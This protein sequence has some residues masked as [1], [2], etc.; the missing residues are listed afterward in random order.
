MLTKPLQGLPVAPV[1]PTSP[2]GGKDREAFE[3]EYRLGPLLGKGGFGT[4]FAGHRVT[5]R[6][7]VAIKVI[8]RNRVLGWSPLVSI[9]GVPD[10][11]TPSLKMDSTP[12][13][14]RACMI[15]WAL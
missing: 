4:V 11:A 3:A 12:C 1:T 14:S 2:P 9:F 13:L 5:D 7:Q 8:P 10:L 15:P 6:L